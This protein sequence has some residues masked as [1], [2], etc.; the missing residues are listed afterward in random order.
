MISTENEQNQRPDRY[1]RVADRIRARPCP[2]CRGSFR[3]DSCVRTVGDSRQ[4]CARRRS[5]PQTERAGG[6]P[7]RQPHPLASE[8]RK[9]H[10]PPQPVCR[11]A[12]RTNGAGAVA[13]FAR[14]EEY[15]SFEFSPHH[16][17]T[18]SLAWFHSVRRLYADH[19]HRCGHPVDGNPVGGFSVALTQVRRHQREAPVDR[20]PLRP[21]EGT[22]TRLPG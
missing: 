17:A 20:E 11:Y 1:V 21:A 13:R 5:S 9:R 16:G 14:P 10:L 18:S 15:T 19:A 7:A 12:T 6:E 3:V 8:P 4:P 22:A 2:T